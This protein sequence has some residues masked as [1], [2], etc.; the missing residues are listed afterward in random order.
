MSDEPDL[1]GLSETLQSLLPAEALS[2]AP[3]AAYAVDGLTPAVVALPATQQEVALVL[4]AADAA[5]ASVL[6]RGGGTQTGLGMP[7]ARYDLTLDLRRLDRVVEH[8]PADLTVTVE[9]GMRLSE[10]QKALAQQGQ[11]LPLDPALP[12]EATI[13][14]VLATSASGPARL[15]Y[16]TARD[17]VIGMSVA[18][19]SG[20]IVKS[21][22]RV[23]KNVAGYDLAKLHI[24][25]LGTLGVIVQAGFKVAPLPQRDVV[26]AV[27]GGLDALAKLADQVIEARLALLGLVLSKRA[28]ETEWTLAAHFAGGAA[29]VERS[30]RETALMAHEA[31]LSAEE[32][33]AEEWRA[34]QTLRQEGA[35]VG[36]CSALPTEGPSLAEALAHAGATV[37]AY[38]G[39]GV[40]YGS[41][42]APPADEALSTLRKR[43]VTAGGALVLEQAPLDLKRRFDV[44]GETRGDFALMQRL[45]QQFD[46]K[47]TLN[48]GRYVGGI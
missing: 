35:V 27:S 47:R 8:E 4:A 10:L 37:V 13:G 36:R 16:G 14:G 20:D 25:A 29:A 26:V 41:F 9:A 3:E 18:L 38:P 23:V 33:S 34:M 6:P 22:G 5:G 44:W 12:D 40:L 7:P 43:C 31:A 15:R 21:G 17:L 46:P 45:K 39:A 24:G 42:D 1:V 2:F 30:Q 32:L 28:A 11:W 19:A 48:P